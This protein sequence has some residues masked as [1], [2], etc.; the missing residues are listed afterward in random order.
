MSLIRAEL[1]RKAVLQE[2]D[3]A[4]M[5]FPHIIHVNVGLLLIT[6]ESCELHSGCI[7]V[8]LEANSV[9]PCLHGQ[10]LQM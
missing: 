8:L 3:W 9:N 7:F 4:L 6:Q 2:E 5:R 1:Y 10:V